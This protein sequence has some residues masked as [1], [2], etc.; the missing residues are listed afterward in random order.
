I[1]SIAEKTEG[2]ILVLFTSYDMLRK[3]YFILKESDELLDYMI[4][5][6]GVST[7]SRNRLIKQFKSFDKAILLGTNAYWQGIDIP[8]EDLSCL[9]IV[10]LPFQSPQD[11]VY[12]K[13]A[14][15]YKM[16]GVNPFMELA[17]PKA[18][19]QFKQGF[20][21][22]IRKKADKGIVFVF[23]DRLMTKKYGKV[24]LQSIPKMPIHYDN[25]ENLLHDVD[26][27]R[28]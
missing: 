28:S 9:I 19:L 10:K 17:L 24:F 18:V 26:N 27:W 6:Q 14:D 2:K 7:G 16:H 21:R 13:K 11:P 20:G 23:D 12:I 3:S 4:I 8:G 5:G 1:I 15:Y 22:L 25:M